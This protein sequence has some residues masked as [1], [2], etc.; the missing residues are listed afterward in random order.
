MTEFEKIIIKDLVNKSQIKI[1]MQYV[2]DTL[3]LVKE[4][5]IKIIH[6]CLNSFDK[7]IK[8]TTDNFP[9]G[10][11]HFL[12]IQIDKS[13]TSNTYYFYKPYIY[14]PAHMGQY[15]HFHSQ[16][17]WPI[18]TAWVKGLFHRAKRICS[19]NVE[20]N[21]QI[22]NIKKLISWNSYPKQVRNSLLKRLNSNINKTKEQTVDDRKK[23]W[24]NLS[25]LGDKG[26]HLTKSLIRILN[27]CFNENVKFIKRYKTNKLG[28]F[29]SNKD[30]IQFQTKANVVDR[31]TCP[32][33][34]NKYIGKTGRNIITRMDQHGTKPDQPMYQHLTNCAQ[35][36]EYLKLYALPDIDDVNTIVNKEMHLDNTVTENTE[37]IDHNDNWDHLQYLEAYYIKTMSPEINIGPKASKELQLFK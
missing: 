25:Y 7:N 13:H 26:D 23:I 10:N 34:Y 32:G 9:D 14:K 8:F 36:A 20:F 33:C 15:A 35:F 27:K 28:M 5:D 3:L 6:K 31:I 21:E 17:P 22:K 4:K 24:L 16:T 2:D 19:S 12:D 11:V 29:C 37:I 1:Y 30:H 18:K